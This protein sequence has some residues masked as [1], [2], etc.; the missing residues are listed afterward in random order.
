MILRRI[1][2]VALMPIVLYAHGGVATAAEAQQRPIERIAFGSCA[3]QQ[4]PCPAWQSI[5]D[6]GPDLMLLLGDNIYADLSNGKLVPSNPKIIAQAYQDLAKDPGFARL[7]SHSQMLA[8]WDDHDYGENDAGV[9]W[10]HKAESARLFHDF[11]GTPVDS[12]RREREGV[13]HSQ[14]FGP[15][16]RRLQVIMLDTRYFRSPLE[17]AEERIPGWRSR[18]YIP[19]TGPDAVLLGEQQWEWLRQQLSEP[20][21]IRIIGSSI[22]VISE[23]HPFEMWANFPDERNR[24]YRLVEETQA[25]GVL[26]IS[27][28]RHLGEISLDPSA[29]GYPLFDVTASGFNQATPKWRP[30]EPNSRRI[31]ALQFGNHFGAIEIDWERNDPLIRLQLRH[32]DGELAVQ[33]HVPLSLL[34]TKVADAPIP[35]PEGVID[36]RTALSSPVGAEVTVRLKVKGGREFGDTGRILLNSEEDFRSDDNLTVVV[37]SSAL[38]KHLDQAG[39]DSFM[40]KLIQVS[41]KISLYRDQ[42]Q[43]VVDAAEQLA[44]IP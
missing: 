8:T 18:P 13:Y 29:V 22:Q 34:Q 44:I 4:K 27:G 17:Q 41:G 9:E 26:I 12:P 30:T 10:V 33:T 19:A 28:D 36:S 43:I 35:L 20:A 1:F 3:N 23:E 14:T 24:L 11:F 5:A 38:V 31:A 15:A 42:R 37:N 6:Y 25:G 40:G 32:E 16:G 39:I 7:R 2:C 21:E